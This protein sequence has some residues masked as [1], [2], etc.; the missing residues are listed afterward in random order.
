MFSKIFLSL[1]KGVLRP[2]S[3]I[4]I[5]ILYIKHI[6]TK[7]YMLFNLNNPCYSKNTKLSTKD[8]E[9]LTC[10]S[11]RPAASSMSELASSESLNRASGSASKMVHSCS[12]WLKA[13][14]PCLMDLSPDRLNVFVTWWLSS[15]REKAKR[16]SQYH[17]KPEVKHHTPYFLH[18]LLEAR[19]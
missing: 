15:P 6:C 10:C 17:V 16:K 8:K 12:C 14:I 5:I 9:G 19:H 3:L 1:C 7:R 11:T 4:T 2:R 18:I 13:S